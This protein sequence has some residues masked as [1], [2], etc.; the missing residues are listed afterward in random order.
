MLFQSKFITDYIILLQYYS[1]SA[2]TYL[3]VLQTFVAY[4]KPTLEIRVAEGRMHVNIG[5]VIVKKHIFF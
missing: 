1:I 2:H 5:T 3:F 4:A